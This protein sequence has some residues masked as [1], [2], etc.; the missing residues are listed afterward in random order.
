MQVFD[1]K[2]KPLTIRLAKTVFKADFR[3]SV[4]PP[5]T[6]DVVILT[7]CLK[8]LLMGSVLRQENWAIKMLFA[9]GR[10]VMHRTTGATNM[11]VSG[12]LAS[13]LG[14]LSSNDKLKMHQGYPAMNLSLYKLAKV[15]PPHLSIIDGFEAMEGVGPADGDQVDL[16]VAIA[17]TDFVAADSL[18]AKIMGFD[19]AQI[20]YLFYCWKKG[21]GEGDVSRMSILGGRVEDCARAFKPHPSYEAQLRWQIKDVERYLE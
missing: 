13:W 4:S 2:L 19:I 15:I 3:I 14:S 12:R 16:G 11:P 7:A 5:K 20:G 17:S 6:H 10:R 1:W 18:A 9:I 8:N 21:L